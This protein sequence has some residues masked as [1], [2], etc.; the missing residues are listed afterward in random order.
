M[1]LIESSHFVIR[2]YEQ[3]DFS[4]LRR[5]MNLENSSDDAEDEFIKIATDNFECDFLSEG[6]KTLAISS[7]DALI[8]RFSVILQSPSIYISYQFY[9]SHDN[10]ANIQ[11]LILVVVKHLHNLYPHREIIIYVAKYD[12]R[13]RS[14]VENFGFEIKSINKV[15]NIYE[16]SLFKP[17]L[18]K[19]AR[20]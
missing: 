18:E 17:N 19:E 10:R 9:E 20:K 7:G 4:E 5:L 11:E 2:N 13:R 3:D 15:S 8:G 12:L 6:E 1:I 16:Y 14:I